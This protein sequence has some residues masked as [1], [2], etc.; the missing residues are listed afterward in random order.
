MKVI[1]S[2][3]AWVLA[4]TEGRCICVGAQSL[5]AGQWHSS[6]GNEEVQEFLRDGGLKGN[7]RT[8]NRCGALVMKK[9][10]VC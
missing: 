6:D 5:Q 1:Y 3:M 4:T 7:H 9:W 8:L 10:M 2:S